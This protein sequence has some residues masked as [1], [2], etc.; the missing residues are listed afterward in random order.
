MNKF[1]SDNELV[2]TYSKE[3]IKNKGVKHFAQILYHLGCAWY[4]QNNT[5]CCPDSVRKIWFP[6]P[7][8]MTRDNH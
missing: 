7:K 5:W 4:H 6:I 2:I 1:P 3:N 8:E